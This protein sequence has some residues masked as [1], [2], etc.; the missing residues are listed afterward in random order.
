MSLGIY[1]ADKGYRKTKLKRRLFKI[2]SV[3][4][5]II[6]FIA[7]GVYIFMQQPQFGKSPTGER[8]DKMKYLPNYKDGKFQNLME[9]PQIK[10][11]SSFSTKF[12]DFFLIKVKETDQLRFYHQLKLT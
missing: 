7:I 6:A 1:V 4:V 12:N 3:S 10:D 8:L 5:S 11:E 9:A 2:V